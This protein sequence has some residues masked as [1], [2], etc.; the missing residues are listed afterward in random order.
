MSNFP[1]GTHP[2]VHL[3]K[4]C[5]KRSSTSRLDDLST[6]CLTIKT[7]LMVFQFDKLKLEPE[8]P[9]QSKNSYQML[10]PLNFPMLLNRGFPLATHFY[11][12]LTCQFGLPPSKIIKLYY[13]TSLVP[14]KYYN[15][16][17]QPKHRSLC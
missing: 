4:T 5:H 7:T 11:H 15:E 13:F 10:L 1:M 16:R 6:I 17:W 12:Q 3:H 2:N 9:F 14:A 8:Q